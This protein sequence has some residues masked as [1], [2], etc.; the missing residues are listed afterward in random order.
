MMN[1]VVTSRPQGND[2]AV[3]GKG[4]PCE[5]RIP[6]MREHSS[7]MATVDVPA[8][9]CPYRDAGPRAPRWIGESLGS[10][11]PWGPQAAATKLAHDQHKAL[12]RG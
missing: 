5:H 1:A 9:M 4:Q 6:P 10:E 12:T 7:T 2:H 11:R 8:S 3:S